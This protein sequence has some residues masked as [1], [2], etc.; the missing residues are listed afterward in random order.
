MASRGKK[1][2]NDRYYIYD[3]NTKEKYEVTEEAYKAY[4][5]ELWRQRKELQKLGKCVCPQAK[6]W[7]CDGDCLS[8][9]FSSDGLMSQADDDDGQITSNA[10]GAALETPEDVFGNMEQ[11]D[12]ARRLLSEMDPDGEQI[13]DL[14]LEG[15]PNSGIARVL[16]RPQSSF[17]YQLKKYR[18]ELQAKCNR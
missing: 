7:M 13:F 9:R 17:V 1:R 4:Y 12:Y 18:A 8:C 11:L 10:V 5:T 16:N 2:S 3:K 15:I 6:L 14:L